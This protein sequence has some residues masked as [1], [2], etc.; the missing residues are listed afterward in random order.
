MLQDDDREEKV[1]TS[2]DSVSPPCK[3]DVQ[4]QQHKASLRR[5]V[6]SVNMKTDDVDKATPSALTLDQRVATR[7]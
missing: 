7:S 4:Q 1:E 5:M 2:S 6:T 3:A